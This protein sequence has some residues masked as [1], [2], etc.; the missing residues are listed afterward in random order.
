MFRIINAGGVCVFVSFVSGVGKL[1]PRPL[2]IADDESQNRSR[3]LFPGYANCVC[4]C[5]Q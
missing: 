1:G 3:H 2:A 5:A 4:G